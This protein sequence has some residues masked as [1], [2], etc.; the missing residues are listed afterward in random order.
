MFLLPSEKRPTLKGKKMLCFGA[1]SFLFEKIPWSNFFS[2]REDPFSEE[3]WCTG[4]QT[5]SNKSCFPCQN[6]RKAT[7]CIN[8]PS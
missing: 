5:G 3:D 4:K 6:G 7:Q 8:S 2:F 1:N